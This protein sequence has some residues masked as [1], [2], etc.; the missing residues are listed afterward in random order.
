MRLSPSRFQ[1]LALCLGFAA[2]LC[3]TRQSHSQ[4]ANPNP[5]DVDAGTVRP[6]D[7]KPGC[8]QVRIED[9]TWVAPIPQ[10]MTPEQMAQMEKAMPPEQLAEFKTVLK[11]FQEGK[12]KV[13]NG[14]DEHGN[15]ILNVPVTGGQQMA[16][17]GAPFAINGVQ[18]YGSETQ[19]CE[20]SID[21]SGGVRRMHIFCPGSAEVP[22]MLLDYQRMGDSYF[23]GT[24][25]VTLEKFPSIV[26]FAGKWMSESTTHMPLSPPSTDLDGKVPRGPQA[27]ASVDGFRVVAMAEGKQIVAWAAITMLRIQSARM[28]KEY[29][30]DP[31]NQFQQLYL[32]WSV[33]NDAMNMMMGIQEPW[34]S[35]LAVEG[36]QNLTPQQVRESNWAWMNPFVESSGTLEPNT[37]QL[38]DAR[39]RVLWDAYFSRAKSDTEKQ[40]MLRQAEE[41][42]KVTQVDS[43][44]FASPT[45]P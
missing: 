32:H 41:K 7:L 29:G 35:R 40:E 8:W 24:G 5:A 4:A 37:I 19:T 14:V 18:V 31:W 44:F 12:L 25:L 2:S 13:G 39:E 30:P 27:V 21:E 43:D 3:L 11:A 45:S 22:Q 28:L 42:Y 34:K 33:A 36:L 26:S 38:E 6:L 23:L 15:K 16:C 17:A 1:F 20:R 10:Q 9:L